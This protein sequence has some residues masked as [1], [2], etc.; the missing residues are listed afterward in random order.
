V[1]K[2]RYV[3]RIIIIITTMRNCVHGYHTTLQLKFKNQSSTSVLQLHPPKCKFYA[4][5]FYKY[6]DLVNKFPCQKIN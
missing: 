1:E 2:D 3:E 4:I 6:D 5:A